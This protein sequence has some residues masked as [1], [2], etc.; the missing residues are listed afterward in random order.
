MLIG[1]KKSL[2]GNQNSIT[3]LVQNQKWKFWKTIFDGICSAGNQKKSLLSSRFGI[4]K[5]T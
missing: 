3:T 4:A 1:E 2:I 5:H